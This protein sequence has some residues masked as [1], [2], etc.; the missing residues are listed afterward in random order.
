MPKLFL[1]SVLA[2]LTMTTVVVV[3]QDFAQAAPK[4]QQC[5]TNCVRLFG[6]NF[7][8]GDV[9]TQYIPNSDSINPNALRITKAANGKVTL[10][11]GSVI[12]AN[13]QS[14]ILPGQPTNNFPYMSRR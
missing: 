10:S 6:F 2:A 12:Q 4:V 7:R 1:A 14:R 13:S 3:A 8:K 11:N 9:V 5:T